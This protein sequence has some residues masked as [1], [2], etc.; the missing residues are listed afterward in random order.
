MTFPLSHT[1]GGMCPSP[2]RWG[3]K[4]HS[5]SS[6]K[7]ACAMLGHGRPRW[8][9]LSLAD[10][11]LQNTFLPLVITS[12]PSRHLFFLFAKIRVFIR[13][14]YGPRDLSYALCRVDVEIQLCVLTHSLHVCSW[15][16]NSHQHISARKYCVK[17]MRSELPLPAPTDMVTLCS[18]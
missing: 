3:P 16:I 17:V 12:L 14:T 13:Q 6:E 18:L 11:S 5:N 9:R 2:S 10:D 7:A 1:P 4:V 8:T 15:R